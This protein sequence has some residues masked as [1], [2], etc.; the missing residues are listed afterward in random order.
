MA[1]DGVQLVSSNPGPSHDVLGHDANTVFSDGPHGELGLDRH[2]ELA[3]HD[4]IQRS[5]QGPRHLRGHDHTPA[6]QPEDDDVRLA[7][8][9][10]ELGE[11]PPRIGSI[12]ERHFANSIPG[13]GCGGRRTAG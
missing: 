1:L 6:W 13:L 7:Q 5:S 12:N 8:I 10:Q 2:A 4:D 9:G 3:D 11:A